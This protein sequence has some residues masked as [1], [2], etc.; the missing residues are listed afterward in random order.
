VGDR[1]V[2]PE[3]WARGHAADVAW[4]GAGETAAMPCSGLEC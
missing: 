3:W 1:P 4:P 2:P